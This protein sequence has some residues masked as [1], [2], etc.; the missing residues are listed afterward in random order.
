MQNAHARARTIVCL[1]KGLST[2]LLVLL[3]SAIGCT[4]F[5]NDYVKTISSAKAGVPYAVQMERLYGDADHFVVHYGFD[6][7][8]RNWQTCVWFGDRYQLSMQVKVDVDYS[9]NT[10]R[11][12]GEPKFILNEV[13]KVTI[14][15]DG[16]I[17]AD[18][19]GEANQIEFGLEEWNT[20]YENDGDFS[21]IGVSITHVPILDFQKFIDAIRRDRIYVSLVE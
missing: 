11:A 21:K 3:F 16:R 14:G 20:L 17:G 9:A 2:L 19:D 13:S 5:G 7:Q 18:Y 4:E 15:S 1:T 10:I 6:D 8:P 12:V